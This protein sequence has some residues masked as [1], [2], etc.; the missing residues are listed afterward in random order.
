MKI[1]IYGRVL[2]ENFYDSFNELLKKMKAHKVQI[3]IYEP[4]Y[5][6]VVNKLPFALVE[7]LTH[8][9]I[10]MMLISCSAL[11]VMVLS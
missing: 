5:D 8:I 3:I 6:S 7:Y 4:L 11:V 10:L 9:M 1:A 2:N